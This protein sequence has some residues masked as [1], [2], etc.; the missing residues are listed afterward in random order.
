MIKSISF[1]VVTL[2]FFLP[3]VLLAQM[4]KNDEKM[5]EYHEEASVRRAGSGD[6]VKR[7]EHWA[8]GYFAN[9]A[10]Y[11]IAV[12]DSTERYVNIDVTQELAE[13]MFGVNRTHKDRTISYHIKFDCDRKDYQYWINEFKYKALEID[14]KNRETQHDDYLSDIKSAAT[15]SLDEEIHGL[16]EDV[17]TSFKAAAEIELED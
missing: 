12:D 7:F 4:P 16:M 15:K 11:T 1:L 3:T 6:L 14:H 5:Y 9:A 10:S 8:N 2:S 13:M 17:I